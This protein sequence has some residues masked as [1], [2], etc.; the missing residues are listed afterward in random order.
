MS[1]T[2]DALESL[3]NRAKNQER[4]YDWEEAA[5]SIE[6]AL[7]MSRDMSPDLEGELLERMAYDTSR[8]AFQ[9]S[10]NE[11]FR[12]LIGASIG[13]FRKAIDAYKR[14]PNANSDALATRCEA[15]C[16]YLSYWL[17]TDLP[18]K[19][20]SLKESWEAMRGALAAFSESKDYLNL[21]LTY[22]RLHFNAFLGWYYEESHETRSTILSDLVRYGNEA[23][24]NLVSANL[25]AEDSARALVNLAS[26]IDSH[27]VYHPISAEEWKRG[28]QM[29]RQCL[30]RATEFSMEAATSEAIYGYLSLGDYTSLGDSDTNPFGIADDMEFQSFGAKKLLDF[31]EK[32]RDRLLHGLAH[33]YVAVRLDWIGAGLEVP[34]DAERLRNLVLEHSAETRRHF[35]CL[36][37]VAP[38]FLWWPWPSAPFLPWYYHRL[39]NRE[40][41]LGKK[42]TLATRLL[43]EARDFLRFAESSGYPFGVEL[44]RWFMAVALDAVADTEEDDSKSIALVKEALEHFRAAMEVLDTFTP[45]NLWNKGLARINCARIEHKL[46]GLMKDGAD[47]TALAESSATHFREGLGLMHEW[48]T[49]WNED[50]FASDKT[51][52]GGFGLW[53]NWYGRALRTEFEILGDRS[54]LKSAVEAFEK[55]AEESSKGEWES[56][57]AESLWDAARTCDLL[58]EYSK[59]AKGFENASACYTEAA[60]KVKSLRE[61]YQ[62]YVAYMRAWAEV[63]RARLHHLRQEPGAAR[64]HYRNASELHTSSRQWGYLA[65][66]Y[67]ALAE[68]ENAEDLS[69][70]EDFAG[71]IGSF[72]EAVKLFSESREALKK[73]LDRIESPDEREMVSRLIEATKFRKD[74]C[75]AR[76]TL[77]EARLLD[78]RGE[79]NDASD[80]YSQ[81]AEMFRVIL[82]KP[83]AGQSKKEIGLIITLASA[84]RAMSRAEAEASPQLY[85]EAA[86]LFEEAKETSPGERAKN[87][88]LGHSRFCKALGLGARFADESDP[89]LHHAATNHLESAARYYTKAGCDTAAEYAR[90]SKLLFDA[91]AHMSVAGKEADPQKKAKSYALAEKLLEASAASYGKI[92]QSGRKEQVLK[93]LDR[94]KRE[95]LLAKSLT[96]VFLAP[97]E[98]SSTSTFSSPSLT[99]ES[100]VGLDRFE[101][102]DVQATL[103][104]R[105]KTMNVGQD[106]VLEVEIVN[107]GRGPAQLTKIDKVIPAGFDVVS[108]PEKCRVEDSYVN[109]KG[110]RLNALKTDDIRLVLR[111][112]VHGEFQ[113]RPRIMYLDESGKYKSC[114][115][116]PI[117][118]W[119]KELGISGWLKG[120]ER[121][122]K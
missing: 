80:R 33:S 17:E 112:S 92:G 85:E 88:T 49:V 120:P 105:P 10:T 95:R 41:D 65:G 46:V 71:S 103:I 2:K 36:G 106:L 50:T 16:S 53:W 93:M 27:A 21:V 114:E 48:T 73:H 47:R 69:L 4:Q 63:E 61:Y 59:A 14:S 6:E 100:A 113:L 3:L 45:S 19:K 108:E 54:F 15:M 37:F 31:A 99:Q 32:T 40:T 62:Q 60:E 89:D 119:V 122:G 74:F 118:I 101:H 86:R 97:D 39:Y 56:R 30:L 9:A 43:S 77:E 44:S 104:A 51:H 117:D 72:K 96:E 1:D 34:E 12:K 7:V 81:A 57:A 29:E 83:G 11:E 64:E 110:R 8:S 90:A 28:Q 91:Y 52:R 13:Q 121:K 84:W 78:K 111:P 116:E 23:A 38:D 24:E 82:D 79:M 58:E 87:L 66:N 75:A 102:A 42:R 98:A 25:D 5:K 67:S 55:A 68:L 107:A 26:S 18:K 76:S 20:R 70:K 35:A 115:P 94:A 109:M 22:N